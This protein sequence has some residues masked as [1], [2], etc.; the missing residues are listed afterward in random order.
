MKAEEKET[1]EMAR[2]TCVATTAECRGPAAE[3]TTSR[4]I[5]GA[6]AG[7]RIIGV[8]TKAAC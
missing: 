8:R 2:L 4:G 1:E 7:R 6:K 3:K 5:G